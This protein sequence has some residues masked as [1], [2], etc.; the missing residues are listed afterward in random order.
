MFDEAPLTWVDAPPPPAAGP[1]VMAIASTV[2]AALAADEAVT[3][4]GATG[5]GRRT[6]ALHAV[7]ALAQRAY[8]VPA[9][10]WRAPEALR[11]I[12]RQAGVVSPGGLRPETLL[13]LASGAMR[14]APGGVVVVDA[15]LRAD[16]GV[17]GDAAPA[18]GLAR[19]P[20]GAR[21]ARR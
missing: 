9:I 15:R 6:A 2:T 14:D 7:A 12:A 16:P 5:S 21:R 18:G 13:T 4:V 17:A 10:P 11:E 3:L 19:H 20:A 1:A 8:V